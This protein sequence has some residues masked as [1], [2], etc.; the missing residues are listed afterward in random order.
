MT[1]SVIVRK[2]Y[3]QQ[4]AKK[5]DSGLR[6][7]IA[8]AGTR[9]RLARLLGINP[10]AVLRWKRVPTERILEIERMVGIPREELRP[11]LYLPTR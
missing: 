11:D 5:I 4:E 7:A 2:S 9:Y 3:S 10:S 1:R 6:M 8:A